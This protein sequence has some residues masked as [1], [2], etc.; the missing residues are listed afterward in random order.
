MNLAHLLLRQ[1]RLQPD[2][3]AIFAGCT[4]HASYGQWAARS[5][6]LARR[7]RSSGVARNSSRRAAIQDS[8]ARTRRGCSPRR[9]A[10]S[11]AA[12]LA[13]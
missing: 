3:A 9:R 11:L 4:V 12:S 10:C 1:A 13:T 5:A 7:L 2:R 6:A 8:V